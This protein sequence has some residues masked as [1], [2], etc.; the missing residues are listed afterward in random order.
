MATLEIALTQI[1]IFTQ[2]GLQVVDNA[3]VVPH[4]H[5]SPWHH[6]H[7]GA[8]HN[9]WGWQAAIEIAQENCAHPRT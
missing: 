8:T 3:P 5:D 9:V 2:G 6:F 7:V 1:E 4:K